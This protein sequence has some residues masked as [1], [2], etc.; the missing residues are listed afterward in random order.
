MAQ[1]QG[2]WGE[3]PVLRRYV[4]DLL[5]GELARLRRS[6]APR[7]LP[8]PEDLD[9]V[10]DLGC[11]SLELLQL[12]TAL[13]EALHLHVSGIEDY[14]LAGR[15]LRDWVEVAATGLERYAATLTFRSSGST[16]EAKGCVHGLAALR[17]EAALHG[18][19]LPDRRRILCAVPCHHVYG[20]LF[21]V[22]LPQELGLP[23]G[24]FV[25]LRASTPAWLAHGAQAGD[26]VIGHPEFWNAVARAVPTLPPDVV[27][28]TSTGPIADA[29]CE[30][31]LANGLA[32]LV[33]VYGAT[34][35]AGIGV[36]ASHR[37]PYILLPW[38]RL[39]GEAGTRCVRRLPD[40]D[41]QAHTVPDHLE[42]AGERSFHVGARIDEAVQ[43]GGVNVYPAH[44]RAVL[45]RHP[46]VQDAAVRLML[47]GEGSRLKAF[48]VPKPGALGAAELQQQLRDWADAAL[49]APERPKA[50]RLGPALPR[51]AA[52][53]LA[54]WPLQD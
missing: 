12:G 25:D 34:E 2:W 18:Q 29:V 46:A 24:A 38:W 53:K 40:G 1:A 15:R 33:H 32:R 23:A 44:V 26:L 43:V 27:G 41:V 35:T 52:G 7:P 50:I 21:G 4:G 36:R 6:P 5:A 28:V 22:L 8:W 47:P 54:D 45:L 42:R 9:L 31:A 19:L 37:D 3:R 20:F 10:A 17:E 14:L 51:T 11:D 49:T 39:E 16:G 13:S 30:R 48:V